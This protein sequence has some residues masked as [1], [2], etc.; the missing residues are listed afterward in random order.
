MNYKIHVL[1]ISNHRT[2]QFSPGPFNSEPAGSVCA[3][4]SHPARPILSE[5]LLELCIQTIEQIKYCMYI[6]AVQPIQQCLGY[7]WYTGDPVGTDC[8]CLNMWDFHAN[9]SLGN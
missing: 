9:W 7:D 3:L 8:F 4:P 5:L 2:S 1:V 6:N